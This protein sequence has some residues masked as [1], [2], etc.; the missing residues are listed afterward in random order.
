MEGFFYPPT[1]SWSSLVRLL[2]F[3]GRVDLGVG[4]G[5]SAIEFSKSLLE[6]K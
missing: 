2:L 4:Q 1:V 6:V 3:D 5:D